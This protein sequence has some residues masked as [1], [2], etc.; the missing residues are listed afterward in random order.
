[1]QTVSMSS[2]KSQYTPYKK[3]LSVLNSPILIKMLQV[4]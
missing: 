1:M 2:Y 3:F 4:M